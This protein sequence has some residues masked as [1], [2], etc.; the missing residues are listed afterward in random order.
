MDAKDM[1]RDL[2]AKAKD[3]LNA[4]GERDP[5]A[6]GVLGG[7]MIAIAVIEACDDV[8]ASKG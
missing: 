3:R 4:T 7:L 1:I 5:Y 2:M 6:E 8:K